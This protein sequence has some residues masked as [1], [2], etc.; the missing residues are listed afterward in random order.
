[1]N[2]SKGEC[3]QISWSKPDIKYIKLLKYIQQCQNYPK[4]Q[5]RIAYSLF[6]D[7]TAIADVNFI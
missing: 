4:W 6:S 1:M 5:F 2:K 3:G 7:Y